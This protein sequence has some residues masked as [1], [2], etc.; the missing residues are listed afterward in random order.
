MD[1]RD[2]IKLHLAL[3][4]II[5]LS[6]SCAGS[7]D[8]PESS[9]PD[10]NSASGLA[11]EVIQDPVEQKLVEADKLIALKKYKSAFMS[12]YEADDSNQ[13]IAAKKIEIAINYHL[14][15]LNYKSFVI[16]DF[17]PGET[18]AELRNNPG[19]TPGI[20]FDPESYLHLLNE[21]PELYALAKAMGDYYYSAYIRIGDLWIYSPEDALRQAAGFYAMARKGEVFDYMSLANEA[22]YHLSKEDFETALE[23][24]DRSISLNKDYP[25]NYYNKALCLINGGKFLEA[26]KEALRAYE[27]YEDPEYKYD[28]A[29]L[30]AKLSFYAGYPEQAESLLFKCLEEFPDASDPYYYL[31]LIY[32]SNDEFKK[33]EDFSIEVFSD[34]PAAPAVASLILKAY[35]SS[36]YYDYYLALSILLQSK[37]DDPEIKGNILFHRGLAYYEMK[38]FVNSRKSLLDAKTIFSLALGPGHQVFPVI[39]DM[40]K[41]IETALR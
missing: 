26:I 18:L 34:Y 2:S 14:D 30:A 8:I 32:L 39:E 36:G 7:P 27:L 3:I 38:D 25:N 19:D 17:A 28:S 6:I 33:A 37:Y 1:T 22:Q 40:L 23:L 13:Y 11:E 5:S 16:K 20:E 12:L 41:K 29:F 10:I 31:V 4:I 9:A 21:N 15:T 24:L 35:S